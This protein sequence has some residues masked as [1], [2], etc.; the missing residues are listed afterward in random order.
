MVGEKRNKAQVDK[1]L[2]GLGG[3]L[4]AAG[5]VE[6]KATRGSEKEGE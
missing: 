1:F 6:G 2:D 4:A 5:A 3:E